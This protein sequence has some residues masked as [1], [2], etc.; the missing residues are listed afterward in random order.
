MKYLVYALLLANLG[1]FAW[2]YTHQDDYRP[3]PPAATA[4]QSSIEP[5]VLLNERNKLTSETPAMS[6]AAAPSEPAPMPEPMKVTELPP[7][8]DSAPENADAVPDPDESSTVAA[9]ADTETELAGPA[10]EHAPDQADVQSAPDPE[11]A[12]SLPRVCQT[13]GPFAERE[14]ADA[15][16]AQLTALGQSAVRR[17]A[18]TEQPSGYWVYLSSMP[19]AEARRTIDEL[20]AKGVKDY[21]LGRQNYISLGIFSERRMAESRVREITALGYRPQLEP[22]FVTREVFWLDFEESGPDYIS[23]EQWRSLLENRPELRRQSLAC[24]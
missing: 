12:A 1:L 6:P 17:T 5:L 13:I 20:A 4:L 19:R 18:V 15:F 14:Q 10:Q 3:V 21:F 7:A 16:S 23:A 8:S 11:P 9:P 2:L 22:R 24:E